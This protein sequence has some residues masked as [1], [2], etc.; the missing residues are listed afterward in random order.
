M[1]RYLLFVFSNWSISSIFISSEPTIFA[2]LKLHVYLGNSWAVVVDKCETG[3][4][5]YVRFL[6]LADILVIR[7]KIQ[8]IHYEYVGIFMFYI[9]SIVLCRSP[10]N[11]GA[12]V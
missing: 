4:Y 10:G 12:C 6:Q 8:F 9:R 3:Y 5:I 2:C 7:A 1:T 11:G